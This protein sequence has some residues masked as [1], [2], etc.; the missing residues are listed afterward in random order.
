M[1]H[2]G[3][4]ISHEIGNRL[5]TTFVTP[6]DREDIHGLIS[7]LDDV[8]DLIEEVADTFV[9]YRIEAPTAVAI[10]QAAIIVTPVRAAPRGAHATCAASRASST[11]GSRSTAS[12]TRATVSPGRP[13]ADLFDEQTRR[14]RDRQV[15][16]RLR[17]A[18]GRHRQVR[19]RRQHHREDRRQA[20][21]RASPLDPQV[22]VVV[23]LCGRL[24]LHQRLPRHGQRHRDVGLDAGPRARTRPSCMSAA[25]NFVGALAG[26]A[27]AT[28]SRRASSRTPPGHERPGGR[29][30]GPDR[31]HRLEPRHLAVRHPQLELPRAHRR[32]DR[33][34][35]RSRSAVDAA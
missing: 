12:R 9:L 28:P 26:T 5:N 17:P 31:R 35:R 34:G 6:F 8:L 10:Q 15:E 25:A 7:G 24:R 22:L 4:E 3:D 29:R 30:C 1:E 32:P 13:I 20:C 33:R 2:H 19:G 18:R 14:R 23:G 21:L 16:G 11:T 27:V